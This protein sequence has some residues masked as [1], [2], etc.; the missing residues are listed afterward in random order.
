[1]QRKLDNAFNDNEKTRKLVDGL[2]EKMDQTILKL[3]NASN[4]LKGVKDKMNDK[5]FDC[6]QYDLQIFL[7]QSS[8]RAATPV[9]KC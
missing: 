4:E 3:E 1:M 5:D 2:D 8:G 7:T 6:V 9:H